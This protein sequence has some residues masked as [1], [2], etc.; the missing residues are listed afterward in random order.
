MERPERRGLLLKMEPHT[1]TV[2]HCERCNTV[3]EPLISKQWFVSIKPLAAPAIAAVAATGASRS[4]PSASRRCTMHWMENIRD[5]NISPPALVGPPHPGVVLRRTATS[6]PAPPNP[7]TRDRLRECGS[8]EIRQD[9]DVLDTWFSSGLW[10]FTHAGLAG[11]DAATATT[12]TR[13]TVMETGY[14][15][16]FFW[17]ARMIMQGLENTGEVPFHTVYLHGLVRDETGAR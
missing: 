1:H 11:Q 13:P 16:L 14:D 7:E 15:I 8:A 9:P 12:S 4:C 5:W 6:S 3:L 2:P 17:V 10:P